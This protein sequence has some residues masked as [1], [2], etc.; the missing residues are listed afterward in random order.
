MRILGFILSATVLH[1][2][3]FVLSLDN[4]HHKVDDFLVGVALVQRQMD[5][6]SAAA[7]SEG[8]E[9]LLAEPTE[10]SRADQTLKVNEA[11]RQEDMDEP[12]VQEL[13]IEVHHSAP[14]PDEKLSSVVKKAPLPPVQR[15]TQPPPPPEQANQPVVDH[16]VAAKA[17]SELQRLQMA[18]EAS[19]PTSSLGVD[20]VQPTKD[21]SVEQVAAQPRYGYH[22]APAYPGIA[23]RRGWEGTVEFNV[24]VLANGSVGE[25]TLKNSSGYKSLDDAARRAITRWRFTPAR[26][27]GGIIESWVVVPVH[28]VLDAQTRSR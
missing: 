4:N 16:P 17:L 23:R 7:S 8:Q 22:P 14:E 3:V 27:A 10:Q 26:H 19:K 5:F 15:P 6:P 1:V 2:V 11:A 9:P 18:T 28:F 20:A 13:P 25:I 12:R 24:R 21:P